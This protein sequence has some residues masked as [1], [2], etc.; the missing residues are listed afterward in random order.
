MYFRVQIIDPQVSNLSCV[1]ADMGAGNPRSLSLDNRGQVLGD[2]DN[3][4]CEN[5][6]NQRR[7]GRGYL[8]SNSCAPD[9]ELWACLWI[10]CCFMGY[11]V[12]FL[13]NFV[14][15]FTGEY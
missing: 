12:Q 6:Q 13:F 11:A 1:S 9:F 5:R 2:Q 14:F 3:N 7:D 4:K 10:L 8:A 15:V